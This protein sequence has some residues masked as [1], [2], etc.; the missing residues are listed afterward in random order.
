MGKG[1]VQFEIQFALIRTVYGCIKFE[2]SVEIKI[3][4]QNEWKFSGICRDIL[5]NK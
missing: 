2:I 1:S 5:L 3:V 4:L